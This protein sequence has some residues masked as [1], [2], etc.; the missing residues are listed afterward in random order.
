MQDGAP[1]AFA[2]RALTDYEIRYAQIGKE[3]L[4]IVFACEKFAYYVY[5]QLVTMQSDHKLVESVFKKS[6]AVNTPRLQ[7]MLLR[8]L[9]FQLRVDYLPSKSMYIA[10]TLSRAYLTELRTR[11]DRE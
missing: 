6:I 9:K 5:G 1:I 7:H 11:S 4:A 3:M 2:L 10:D 8:L